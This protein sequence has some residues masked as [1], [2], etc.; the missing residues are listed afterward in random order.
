MREFSRQFGLK[1]EDAEY[2]E[3][4]VR[5]HLTMSNVA[6]KQDIADPQVV[7]DFAK[8]VG[9]MERLMGLYL[10]TVCD[11]RGNKSHGLD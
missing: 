8:K 1:A 6:Q 3:F 11:I 7:T 10:I 5:E 9:T 2:I 4:L